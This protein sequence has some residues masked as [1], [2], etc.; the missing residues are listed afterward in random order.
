MDLIV[1]NGDRE[2]GESEFL[3]EIINTITFMLYALEREDWKG[4]F[5]TMVEAQTQKEEEEDRQAEIKRRRSHL[6]VVK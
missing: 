1:P 2:E 6:K 4:E 5:I 3:D